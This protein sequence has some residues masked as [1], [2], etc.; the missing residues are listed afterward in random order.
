M[1]RQSSIQ[2]RFKF[3]NDIFNVFQ[4]SIF[5]RKKSSIINLV[6]LHKQLKIKF[7]AKENNGLL[8]NI[9]N[10]V[11]GLPTEVYK[12]SVANLQYILI[13]LYLSNF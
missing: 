12:I 3:K 1:T 11:Q 5:F 10:N 6:F 7:P 2:V 9:N 4:T 13:L 8:N